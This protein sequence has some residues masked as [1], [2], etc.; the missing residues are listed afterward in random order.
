[1]AAAM[2]D[3]GRMTARRFRA[4]GCAI[5]L[6]AMLPAA[7]AA[8]TRVLRGPDA[9]QVRALVVGLDAYRHVRPLKGAVAD[10]L[11]IDQALRRMGV[12]DITR[13]LDDQVDR[14]ALL[15]EINGLLART[16]RGDFVILSIAGHGAQEP[17][18]VKGSQ[19]DG[20]DKVFLLPGFDPKTAE[21]GR[22][23][24]LGQEFNHLIKQFEGRGA[25]VMFVADTCYAGG[26]TRE[27]DPRAAE[28][29]YRQV[30]RY[31]LA[32]D[33]LKPISTS[34]DSF[35]TELDF[36]KS[37]FLAAVDRYTKAPEVHIPGI[38]GLRGALSYAIARAI[39]GRAD[40]D[41][42]GK[43]T[44]QELF[45][46]VRQVVYQLSDQRQNAVTLNAPSRKI[47]SDV[48]FE[49]TRSVTVVDAA[50]PP[51]KPAAPTTVSASVAPA[52]TSEPAAV[53]P[54]P[55]EPSIAPVRIA[56]LDGQGSRLAGLAKR[57]A[58]F[59]VVSPRDHPDL[60]WD[61]TS[62]DVIAGGDVIA[63]AAA[64]TDLPSI[65]DRAAAVRAFK[66]MGAKAPQA[67]RLRPNDKLHHSGARIEVEVSD[68]SGRSMI[69]FNIAG[70]GTVQTLY[71]VGSDPAVLNTPSYRFPV[72]VREPFGADQVVVITSQQRM[73]ALEQALRLLNQRRSAMQVFRMV[74][75]YGPADAKVGS[76]GLFTAQ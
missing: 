32:I 28:M 52:P 61:P 46:N 37:A 62:N 16:Q 13:M 51:A 42:N 38:E 24:I 69:M 66:M 71:P 8:Q 73:G 58:P 25:R 56:S 19:P 18:R 31:T 67:I 30:P 10:A 34:Q 5:A 63:Y 1:M 55:A 12:R 3:A 21:G 7:A 43:V 14:A 39:E 29:S 4:L 59:V 60:I 53:A 57:E 27:V 15:R 49:V 35:L 20:Q 2:R 64:Q 50:P 23:K 75:R 17:E 44:L 9:G 72:Q 33:D 76:I 26:L 74:E 22:E 54:T 45:A 65:L 11:D 36:E 40:T 47:E 41:G 70:D 48:A 6:A 68:V